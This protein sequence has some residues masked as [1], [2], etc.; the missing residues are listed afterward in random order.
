V[1]K[2]I[3]ETGSAHGKRVQSAGG[4]KNHILIMPDADLEQAALAVQASAFGCAGERCMAGSI[5]VP[6]GRAA[7]PLLER[8]VDIG[9]KMRTGP[10][11]TDAAVDMGPLITRAHQQRVASYLEIAGQEGAKVALDGRLV[12]A[13]N[14]DGFFVGPSIVDQVGPDM[15]LARE[16]IFGPVLSV[17]RVDDLDAALAVGKKCTYGNGA[18]IFTKSGWAARQF[19]QYFNAGMIGI[20]IGVPAPMAWFPFTGWNESFF[21]DLHIQGMESVQF[22]TQQRTITTRWFQ[23]ADE[24]YAD[25]VWKTQ[26]L[27]T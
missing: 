14:S 8:L 26:K 23:S 4:A 5:A 12:A 3:Y 27:K 6:I 9:Q 10:T 19:K 17:C 15:R 16:E 20:N 1:A 22:Y 21:G 25:P 11:D 18:S 13:A 24:S 2:Y 7:E